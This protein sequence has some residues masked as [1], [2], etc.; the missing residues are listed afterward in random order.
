MTKVIC[1][2]G[3]NHFGSIKVTRE[4]IYGAKEAGAW[5]IKFQYRNLQKYFLYKKKN[6]E[7]GKEII[8]A[9]LKK[10]YLNPKQI[11]YLS[12]YAASIGLNVGISFFHQ[13]DVS[14][15]KN[16]KFDFYKVPSVAALDFDLLNKLSRF[17]KKNFYISRC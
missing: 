14:D 6:E 16:Y 4:L 8:D 15:F 5:G 13:D 2:I 17:K 11:I 9:E 12:K 10:N 3:I 7:I 1:E